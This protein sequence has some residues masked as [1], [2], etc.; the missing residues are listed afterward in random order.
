M[1]DSRPDLTNL[2]R[3]PSTPHVSKRRSTWLLPVAVL[4]GFA[5]LFLGLFRDRL[6]PARQVEVSPALAI[7][8]SAPTATP[9]PADPPD[10]AP[11]TAAGPLLFQASGWIEP[12]PLPIK[13]TALTDGFIDQVHVLEGDSVKRNDPIVTLIDA[14]ARLTRDSAAAD[15]AILDAGLA[16]LGAT[17]KATQHQQ[18]AERA[19]L[20]SAQ[21][22]ATEAA[23]RLQRIERT[24]SGSIPETERITA[25]LENSRRQAAV[26]VS[27]ALIEQSAEELQRIAHESTAMNARIT[28][29][30]TKLA[31]AELDLE[32]TR[33]KAPISGRVLRL[34]ATPGQKKMSAGDDIDSATVA[35]LYD[36]AKLQVRVDIP[37]ADAAGLSVGQQVR[38]RCNLLPDHPFIGVVT[39]INGEADL[40]RNTLQAKVRIIDPSDQLRPEMLC[41]AEFLAPPT[42]TAPSA[43]AGPAINALAIFVP[44]DAISD[45]AVWICDP[46][47]SR[48]SRRPVV[49]SAETRDGYRRLNSG[50]RPG[51]WIVRKPGNLGEG[52]RVNPNQVP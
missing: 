31:Q 5:F 30:K 34:L 4:L 33:I 25:R 38:I 15:V 32:R 18:E 13:V 1:S 40:Q 2:V 22:D 12:D 37:L 46:D 47:T 19:G 23:D 8:G 45:S 16:A 26:R 14:D 27:Q 51:E 6:I 3:H 41:R 35:I 21:A 49:A 28:A 36:P 24:S 17:S 11:P 48:V 52:Q 50:V 29:A 39:R 42:A 10:A 44:D 43:A 20:T 9:P 7:T